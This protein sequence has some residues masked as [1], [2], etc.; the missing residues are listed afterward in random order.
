MVL[1]LKHFHPLKQIVRFVTEDGL[2]LTFILVE[3]PQ[4]GTVD[5][6][7]TT[8]KFVT[9]TP[10]PDFIGTDSFRFRVKNFKLASDDQEVSIVVGGD[11]VFAL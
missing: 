5:T 8:A 1:L 11:A 6:S 3:A 2:A 9:Y 4:C 7:L 10:N